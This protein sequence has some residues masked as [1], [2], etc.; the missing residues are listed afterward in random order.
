MLQRLVRLLLC[1]VALG[2]TLSLF[3]IMV[4]LRKRVQNGVFVEYKYLQL[5]PY[6]LYY[7]KQLRPYF[8]S[9]R[10]SVSLGFQK[11]VAKID[12]AMGNPQLFKQ[13]HFVLDAML[14]LSDDRVKPTQ[15]PESLQLLKRDMTTL[16]T[17]LVT[18]T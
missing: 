5:D 7:T 17:D 14:F 2:V 12:E 8:E 16:L 13:D 9:S 4:Q 10:I 3:G 11:F 18:K 1:G 6:I 15:N